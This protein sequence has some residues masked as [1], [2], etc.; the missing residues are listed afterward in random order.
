LLFFLKYNLAWYQ[1]TY[2]NLK[3]GFWNI[4]FK[5]VVQTIIIS[6]IIYFIIICYQPTQCLKYT[7]PY[8]V[9]GY[10]IRLYDFYPPQIKYIVPN[11]G[12]IIEIL[13][14]AQSLSKSN[15][16]KYNIIKYK[17]LSEL[18][19]IDRFS[20]ANHFQLLVS[21]LIHPDFYF[22]Y[23]F[24]TNLKQDMQDCFNIVSNGRIIELDKP[25]L[26]KPQFLSNNLYLYERTWFDVYMH[27]FEKS[28]KY[29]ETNK[30]H[31]NRH[32]KN[33]LLSHNFNLI[34]NK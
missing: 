3:E 24:S 25:Q 7:T 5:I 10:I 17:P 29:L 2:F 34:R 32:I 22:S 12:D 14:N 28:S 13:K 27:E 4:N 15:Q 1:R 23:Q 30:I 33:T 11:Q 26:D 18:I 20:P 8:N 6:I 9:G 19:M 16:L 31:I 21:N